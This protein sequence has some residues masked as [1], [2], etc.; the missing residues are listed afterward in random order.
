MIFK[1]FE[2][3]VSFRYTLQI[4][5]TGIDAYTCKASSLPSLD[6]GE[7]VIDYINTD[8]KVKGKSRWQDITVTLYDPCDP[9]Q[10]KA[11]HDWIS[12][13]HHNS[14][15]GSD[16]FA[17]SEYK[18]IITLKMQDPRGGTVEQWNMVGAWVSAV[19]WG[20]ADWANEEAK[21]IELTIKYDY[22]FLV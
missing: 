5:G 4:A 8:F 3:K 10:A 1:E 7:I 11:V 17:F 6:Q 19:N 13:Q 15:L 14:L 22:A 12:I 9:S 2:P 21:L 18:K 16:G 20:E